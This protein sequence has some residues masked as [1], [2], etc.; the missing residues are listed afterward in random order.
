MLLV[1][2]DIELAQGMQQGQEKKEQKVGVV[3]RGREMGYMGVAGRGVWQGEGNVGVAERGVW[4]GE[5]E[6][7]CGCHEYQYILC[8]YH[9]F[10]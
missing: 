10:V 4:Q 6:R 2:G 9:P 5:G 7:G 8:Y 1:L 3:P